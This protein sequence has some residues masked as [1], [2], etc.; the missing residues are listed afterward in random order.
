MGAQAANRSADPTSRRRQAVVGR[1]STYS[2]Y[3]LS[4]SPGSTITGQR[5]LTDHEGPPDKLDVRPAPLAPIGSLVGSACQTRRASRPM[6]RHKRNLAYCGSSSRDRHPMDGLLGDR[7]RDC[8]SHRRIFPALR[9]ALLRS[10]S[11]RGTLG[12][13]DIDRRDHT[14]QKPIEG[15]IPT[16]SETGIRG[17]ALHFLGHFFG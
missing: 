4:F 1:I 11:R 8:R 9:S 16:R 12:S 10:G 2:L 7:P 14:P 3:C 6:A 13:L 5:G 15:T 17:G